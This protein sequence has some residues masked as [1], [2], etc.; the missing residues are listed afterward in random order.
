[1][2][3][4]NN[5]ISADK[6]TKRAG[7]MWLFLIIIALLTILYINFVKEMTY[8]NVYKNITEISEQTATQL[9]LSIIEQK[10]FVQMMVDSIS[11]GYFETPQ[12]IFDR[13][14]KE[15]EHHHFTRLVI[16]DKNGNGITSD[17]H[18]VENY[19]N[20]GEFF[21]QE[22]VYLSENRP[23]TVSDNQVNIYSKTFEL[24]GEELVLMGTINTE[25][26]K[27]ILV[28]RLFGK[29][30]TYLIN[31]DGSVLINSF[32]D[33]KDN[34]INLYN[35]I[36]NRYELTDEENVNKIIKM[37]ENIKGK[38]E[39]TFDVRH[40][41]TTYFIHYENI[42]INDWYIVTVAANDTIAKE[43]FTVLIV[44][45]ILFL[46]INF[47]VLITVLC[48]D[49]SNY[50]KSCNLY[51][52]AYVDPVTGLGNEAYF[53][54]K[55]AICLD[56]RYEDT[57]IMT[58]D[59]DKFKALN[60]IYGYEFCNTVLK[61][62]GEKLSKVLPYNN[63]ISRIAGDVFAT[64]FS[65]DKDIIIL[66]NKIVDEL[67]VLKI[68]DIDIH[69]K[70]SM[71][72]CKVNFDDN[73]INKL[74]DKSYMSRSKVKGLYNQNYYIFD[75]VLENQ[76]VEEQKI[77]S[78]MEE[79]LKNKEFKVV[80]QPKTYTKT[81]KLSGAEALVRWERD[82]EIIPP[83]KFIALFEKNKFI[84]KLDLYIFEQACS[85]IASWIE[86]FNFQPIVS[87]NVSKE[88]FINENFIEEYVEIAN[89][90]NVD[91]SKIDLEITESAIIDRNVDTIKILNNIKE[92]G[93]TI[94]IDDFGTGYSSLSMLQS[95]PIDVIKI[96]KVFVDKADLDSEKNIINY[97]MYLAERLEV[98]TIVEGVE[99]K[100]QVEFIRKLNCDVIQGYY[101]SKPLNKED[102]E[103]YMEK[104][105]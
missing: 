43:F 19:T 60:N 34:N 5:Q 99:T 42:G 76:L 52:V 68:N 80:Y 75:S 85:D 64:I 55:A 12:D 97:I 53:K 87:I 4:N 54:E 92:K 96:D 58:I 31:N 70:L 103:E 83:S 69:I 15:L 7:W 24:N 72:V 94:S 45:A 33:I 98:R 14:E 29:G 21:E 10:N 90:Y 47:A 71:G 40:N 73:D 25:K 20:I 8:K 3:K 62:F 102:F 100:E 93:F 77:E 91:R 61:D 101:Y 32:E 74:L 105:R 37:G 79:A 86:K 16:L 30:G 63:V 23:S 39:G 56:N 59:I 48:I 6:H 104:N 82:G 84:V 22:E 88:H 44:T 38:T 41:D 95:T 49:I 1:M 26:Y 89:K 28:R 81:E 18:V 78:T 66:L 13:F 51:R 50:K 65:S 67:S 11:R 46:G 27:E 9:N 57:Y 36:I 35:Y 17:G 2:K